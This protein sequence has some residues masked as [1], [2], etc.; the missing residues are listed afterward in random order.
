MNNFVV[1]ARKS[2]EEDDRQALS[3][4]AQIDELRQLAAARGI[5]IGRI[6]EEARSARRPGRAVFDEMMSTVDA[7]GVD[8]IVCWKADRLARN[9]IDGGRIIDAIDRGVL[10]E[11][12][13]PGR[14]FRDTS[15]DKLLLG[16]EF[17]M[18]KKY[19]DDLSDNI[20]R[21]NRAV[22]Q[23][24]RITGR[25]PIGYLKERPAD[26]LRGRGAGQVVPDP[27]RFPIVREV[28]R[29]FLTGS[30][31]V[32][33]LHAFA[34]DELGLTCIG[35]K[36]RPAGPAT[37]GGFYAFLRNPFYAGIVRHGKEVYTGAHQPLI[38]PA[39]FQRVQELLDRR[40]APRPQHRA[41]DYTGLLRC[42]SCGRGITAEEHTNRYGTRYV[43]YR[44]SR[45]R[46]GAEHCTEPYIPEPRVQAQLRDLLSRAAVPPAVLRW[47]LQKIR[48]EADDLRA[49]ARAKVA[50][51]RELL[52]A[53][54]QALAKLVGLVAHGTITE[55]EY[56]SAKLELLA[57]RDR[58]RAQMSGDSSESASA[59][60]VALLELAATL[61]NAFDQ[62]TVQDRRELLGRVFAELRVRNR[63]IEATLRPPFALLVG[64]S[65]LVAVDD[66]PNLPA[67]ARKARKCGPPRATAARQRPLRTT[68]LHA[69]RPNT[70][71]TA[72]SALNENES[73][74]S[75]EA[76]RVPLSIWWTRIK[77]LR[78][79][80]LE[81]PPRTPPPPPPSMRR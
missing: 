3:I 21:G 15:D 56:S 51:A 17:G 73:R 46:V 72:N 4:A 6:Y 66:R 63:T 81:R 12:L 33:A 36:R 80:F 69:A 79:Y 53:K 2:S 38:T 35:E 62:A 11:I 76:R 16:L 31:S 74:T 5:V 14:S 78:T 28:F 40:R 18:S 8:G 45:E 37:L 54:D 32:R 70:Q 68:R 24:G 23:S 48:R 20:K 55:D 52:D 47:A 67:A 9:W 29:R 7:G 30:W 42:G 39:E 25:P 60:C 65:D 61:E 44:C 13:I 26:V 50:A 58:L 75:P 34:T 27:V 1:Y 57:E 22:V 41:F 71:T 19:V 49:A 64:S 43:Y 59:D 77:N 10:P